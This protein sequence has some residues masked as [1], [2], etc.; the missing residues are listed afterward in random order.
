MQTAED[1]TNGKR[2]EQCGSEAPAN[3]FT[4]KTVIHRKWCPQRRKQYVG[5]TN[6]T[7]CAGTACGGHLQ[8][9]YEG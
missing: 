8:M 5:R 4:T 6:F 2:C 7:V 9:G 3:G 1:R